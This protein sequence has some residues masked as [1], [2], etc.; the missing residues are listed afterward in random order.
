M[1]SSYE[2]FILE[3]TPAYRDTCEANGAVIFRIHGVRDIHDFDL[4]DNDTKAQSQ[5]LYNV[6]F[7]GQELWG[8]SAEADETLHIDMWES[9]LD[10]A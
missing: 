3:A 5:P 2:T 10:P 4:E 7:E 8:E 1:R 9:Y 6:R